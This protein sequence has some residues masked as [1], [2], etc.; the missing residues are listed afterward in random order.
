MAET[1]TQR[2]VT[3]IVG[4]DAFA[5]WITY[6]ELAKKMAHE[7]QY[8]LE[9]SD[10]L[11]KVAQY[12]ATEETDSYPKEILVREIR[13]MVPSFI[14]LQSALDSNLSDLDLPIFIT[15]NY[16]HFMEASLERRGK[17]PVS[18]F[19]RW[20]EQLSDYMRRA[21]IHSVFDRNSGTVISPPLLIL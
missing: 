5:S 17:R 16:D 8:P 10:D 4:P 15:T 18:E 6:R 21:G 1:I 2:T 11:P 7:Y 19:C 13:R 9:P 3:P 14:S 20:N 12:L